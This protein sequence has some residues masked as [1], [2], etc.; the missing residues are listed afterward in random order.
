MHT[1]SALLKDRRDI[2]AQYPNARIILLGDGNIHTSGIL[3][4]PEGCSCPHC[5]PSS[6]DRRIESMFRADGLAVQ[7]PGIPTHDSGYVL[8]LVL[9]SRGFPLP[10]SVVPEI[11]GRSDHRLV[12]ADV[13][14]SVKVDHGAS[15]G[16]VSWS[17]VA[18]WEAALGELVPWLEELSSIIEAL[19]QLLERVS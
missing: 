8:D 9:C 16:R 17:R 19:E 12:V 11:I 15:V 6:V 3:C 10:V 5:V 1:W 14:C 7:N 4:H 18:D 13:G 2:M